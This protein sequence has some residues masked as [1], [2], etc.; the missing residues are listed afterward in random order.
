MVDAI[1]ET[2]PVGAH[3]VLTAGVA[4]WRQDPGFE[5]LGG[6]MMRATHLLMAMH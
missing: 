2:L 3:G 6:L 5:P 4:A 1:K